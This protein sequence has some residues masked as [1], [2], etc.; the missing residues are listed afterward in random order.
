MSDTFV[1]AAHLPMPESELAGFLERTPSKKL[2]TRGSNMF[3][4][5]GWGGKKSGWATSGPSVSNQE[6]LSALVV[7]IAGGRSP[8][9]L[10]FAHDRRCDGFDFYF[11]LL[12]FAPDTV[13]PL[14]L[15]LASAGQSFR[16]GAEAH[17]VLL[18]EASGRLQAKGVLSVLSIGAKGAA[19]V[20]PEAVELP[21]LLR[22]LKPAEKRFAKAIATGN[23]AETLDSDA[24]LVP[25]LRLP[26]PQ[27]V[28]SGDLVRDLLALDANETWWGRSF[29]AAQ[30]ELMGRA[31]QERSEVVPALL[32]VARTGKWDSAVTA[33]RCVVALSRELADPALA[34]TAVVALNEWS[35]ET[36]QHG[37]S[38]A[39]LKEVPAAL[40][41][42]GAVLLAD[43]IEARLR[44]RGSCDPWALRFLLNQP[45]APEQLTRLSA[46]GKQPRRF[47][48][49]DVNTYRFA[50]DME[51]WRRWVFEGW[52]PAG[53]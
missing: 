35:T 26:A 48:A 30:K 43:A 17:A 7:E 11:T 2:V 45:G 15:L 5:W 13:R 1:L 12:G 33:L 24:I 19:F 22:R 42:A 46:A 51:A 10:V 28:A 44:T 34:V 21:A 38:E 53:L 50:M 47:S 3:K 16:D 14:M 6:L 36:A 8:A 31:R 29:S 25:E 41:P 4:G 52:D 27:A 40:G 32:E 39:L 20:G 18:A 37:C 9:A 23:P 49:D